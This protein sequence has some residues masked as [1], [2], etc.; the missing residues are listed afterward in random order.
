MPRPNVATRYWV[1]KLQDLV[2]RYQDW[3]RVIWRRL[4]IKRHLK[5]RDRFIHTVFYLCNGVNPRIIREFYRATYDFDRSAWQHVNDLIKDYPRSSWTAWNV[6][7]G[8]TM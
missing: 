6:S 8:K 5:Y 7:Q 1:N 3:P 2:G 4:F